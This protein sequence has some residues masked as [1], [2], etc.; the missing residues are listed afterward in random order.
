MGVAVKLLGVWV[1][2]GC[3]FWQDGSGRKKSS[4]FFHW[5]WGDY[6]FWLLFGGQYLLLSDVPGI[7]GRD[8]GICGADPVCD[9]FML[10]DLLQ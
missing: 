4:S 6:S 1:M 5:T 10:A 2:G 3:L 7:P 9:L 8:A